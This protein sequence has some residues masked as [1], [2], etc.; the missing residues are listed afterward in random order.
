MVHMGMRRRQVLQL[1]ALAL[2]GATGCGHDRI[3]DRYVIA[4][5]VLPDTPVGLASYLYRRSM[6]EP[7][8]LLVAADGA[9]YLVER[10]AVNTPFTI[11]LSPSGRWLGWSEGA[12]FHLRDLTA[13]TVRRFAGESEIMGAWWSPNGRWLLLSENR[14]DTWSFVDLE[15][16]TV[17]RPHGLAGSVVGLSPDGRVLLSTVDPREAVTTFR[18]FDPGSGQS[19]PTVTAS[20]PE[21]RTFPGNWPVLGI[22]G[23]TSV[24]PFFTSQSSDPYFGRA[25]FS[26][27]VEFDLTD[28]REVVRRSLEPDEQWSLCAGWVN[29]VTA[30]RRREGVLELVRLPELTADPEVLAQ[31]RLDAEVTPPGTTTH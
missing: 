31:F 19:G 7:F 30:T 14:D 5:V 23:T 16:D 11:T 18:W 21:A 17:T 22:E 27:L 2:M 1:G 13:R 26:S 9:E 28:G 29:G 6:D 4:A 25:A 3:E 10:P 20:A 15:A 8:H 24:V 12:L